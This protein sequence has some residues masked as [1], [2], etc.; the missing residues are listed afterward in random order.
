MKP[1]LNQTQAIYPPEGPKPKLCVITAI[2]ALI[3]TLVVSFG[4]V[5]LKQLFHL[6]VRNLHSLMIV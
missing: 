4:T 1:E 2:V 3:K 6:S 5:P